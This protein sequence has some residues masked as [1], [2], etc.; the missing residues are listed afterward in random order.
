MLDAFAEAVAVQLALPPG[1]VQRE[2]LAG[3]CAATIALVSSW[4]DLPDDPADWPAHRHEGAVMLAARL[5]RRRNSPSG[6]EA[7]NE[8][9]AV[10]VQRNDPDVAL[11]LGLGAHTEP[12]VG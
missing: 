2:L 5:H 10:Y 3:P 4:H 9:G 12:R 11:L 1:D 6:V 8:M 7:F